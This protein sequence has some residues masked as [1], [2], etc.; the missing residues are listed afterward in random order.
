M[1]TV[2]GTSMSSDSD[3]DL[4]GLSSESVKFNLKSCEYEEINKPYLEKAANEFFIDNY[5]FPRRYETKCW[6]LVRLVDSF[7]YS[8]KSF[9]Q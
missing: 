6:C 9:G 3:H 2:Q 1:L 8:Y 7:K 4:L 5:I